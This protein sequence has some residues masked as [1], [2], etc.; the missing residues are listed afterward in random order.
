MARPKKWCSYCPREATHHVKVFGSN[1]SYV[2]YVHF[3]YRED[4]KQVVKL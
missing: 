3:Y 4:D 1:W 2:C